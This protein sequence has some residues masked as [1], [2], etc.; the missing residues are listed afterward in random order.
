MMSAPLEV[1]RSDITNFVLQFME[2]HQFGR[3]ATLHQTV[4]DRSPDGVSNSECILLAEMHWTAVHISET[5]I[6]VD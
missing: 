4:A 2:I 5:G 3:I 6:P 1:I